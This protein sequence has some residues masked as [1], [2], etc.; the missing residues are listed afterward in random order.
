MFKATK[1]S[2][3]SSKCKINATVKYMQSKRKCKIN[4]ALCLGYVK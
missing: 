4:I 2:K 3:Y 1:K